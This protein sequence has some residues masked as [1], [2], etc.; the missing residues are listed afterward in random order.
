MGRLVLILLVGLAAYGAALLVWNGEREVVIESL[1]PLAAMPSPPGRELTIMTWNIGYAGLGA[2]SDFRADGGKSLRPP[3]RQA[4][5]KNRAG[6]IDTLRQSSPD[7][8]LMQETARPSGLTRGVDVLGAIATALAGRDNAFSVDIGPRF[9]PPPFN[10]RNG[11]FT[12][13]GWGGARREVLPLPLEPRLFGA[14]TRHYH[15]QVI[16]LPIAGDDR[17]WVIADVHLSAFDQGAKTRL[18]QLRAALG[19]AEREYASGNYV[20]LGGDWNLEFGRPKRLSTTEERFLS[21][22][23]PFPYAELKEGWTAA[24]D[25]GVPSVRTNERP[26]R[27]GENFTTIIDGFIVSPNVVLESVAAA[28]LDFQWTDHH[29]ATARFHASD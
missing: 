26:Y 16:R 20:V 25:A 19:F 22:V 24:F 18:S 13:V 1:G 8:I 10:I 21:W 15:A 27:R 12:S 6:V 2:E 14:V 3:S 11:L 29:P 17:E 7:V 4:V 28:D 5:E 9:V 23:H